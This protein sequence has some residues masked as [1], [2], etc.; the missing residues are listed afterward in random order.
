LAAVLGVFAVLAISTPAGA[1]TYGTIE[2]G[3]PFVGA[4]I[5]D[6]TQIRPDIGIIEWC[7]GTLVSPKVF[8]TA[9]HCVEPLTRLGIPTNKVWVSFAVNIWQNPNSWR[10]VASWEL[11]PDYNWGPTSDPHDIGA[12]VLKKAVRD[13]AP[14]R[15]AP[16]GFL[17]G[18]ADAGVLSS[19]T[20]INVGYGSNESFQVDG[21]RKISHSSFLSLHNAWL[22]MSQN[23]HSDGGGTCFGDSG[24][25][26]FYDDG[27]AEW[28]VATVSW[29]D[30]E[31]VATNINYRADLQVG[32]DFVY[33]VIADTS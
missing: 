30:A 26:T 2:V 9:G 11:H 6:L 16:V 28:I 25:P 22:Y 32:Q 3:H 24:G 15:I 27:T 4:I 7:S 12:L 14:A 29:G 8:L 1:I 19:A 20:F 18:L 17:D 10:S 31:C 5:V 13:I 21:W 33:G 23:I